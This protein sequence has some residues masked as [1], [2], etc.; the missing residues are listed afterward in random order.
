[1]KD[2]GKRHE[3]QCICT[4]NRA[5]PELWRLAMHYSFREN[6]GTSSTLGARLVRLAVLRYVLVEVRVELGESLQCGDCDRRDAVSFSKI[7]HE[8][9][10]G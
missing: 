1:M 5:D 4:Q 3:G 10:N 9:A 8:V 6:R 7:L 2:H